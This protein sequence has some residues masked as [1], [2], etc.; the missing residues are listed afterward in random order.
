LEANFGKPIQSTQMLNALATIMN[1]QQ[2]A[3]LEATTTA[4]VATYQQY[5][6]P[7]IRLQFPDMIAMNVVSVI[8]TNS[9]YGV[10][11]AIRHLYENGRTKEGPF[12]QGEK[13]QIGFDLDQGFTGKANEEAY[14]A[15][16]T[17]QGEALSNWSEFGDF[18][19]ESG[20]LKLPP[21]M[22]GNVIARASIKV[23]RGAI[24]VG[25]R[26]I[27]SHYTLEVQQDMAAQQGQDVEALLLEGL[28]FENQMEID[29]ELLSAMKV[30]S[31]LGQ[32]GGA[33]TPIAV[34]MSF[35]RGNFN[36]GRWANERIAGGVINTIIGVCNKLVV[37]NRIGRG[38][39]CI[40]SADI[41][42]CI[43]TLNNGLYTAPPVGG[44]R[45]ADIDDNIAGGVSQVGSL[46]GG[47]IKVY[48]DIFATESYALVGFKGNKL[49]E[50]GIIFM[51]YIPYIF[52]KTA[53]QEDASPRLIV[54]SR[55]AIVAN[56]LGCGLFYRMIHFSHTSSVIGG[57]GEFDT[58]RDGQ[59]PWDISGNTFDVKGASF[60]PGVGGTQKYAAGPGSMGANSEGVG[61]A[62]DFA[63][64]TGE[65]VEPNNDPDFFGA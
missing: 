26:A 45:G 27:K 46:L 56:L 17:K 55:Y 23:L 31:E 42:A 62:G 54:K 37:I 7:L 8:P 53:G 10:Y 2:K 52:A 25:T 5:A 13:W 34:D 24:I 3:N 43:S 18:P 61:A 58:P 11:F 60:G 6:L 30:V 49:G 32:F 64:A 1:N 15:W 29:R 39:F 21:G 51:P 40:A 19:D 50:S 65:L 57:F 16:T 63:A 44:Y 48:L 9:P 20:T 4:D 36:D 33:T 35:V 47:T 41:V 28:Q 14:G 22:G 59:F 12:R 38:N